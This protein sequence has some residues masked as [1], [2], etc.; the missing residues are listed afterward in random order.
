MARPPGPLTG[1]PRLALIADVSPE[2]SGGGFLLLHRLLGAYPPDRL[3][4]IQNPELGKNDPGARLAGVTYR[5]FRYRIPRIYRN[6]FNPA[7]PILQARSMRRHSGS[8]AGMIKA[9]APEA[10]LTIP[11][12]YLWSSAAAVAAEMEIPLHLI[13]HDDW[14]SNTTFRKPG[15]VWDGVRWGCRRVLGSIYRQAVSRLCVSPGMEEYC[16]RWFGAQGTLLYPSWGEDSPKQQ[17][18]VRD[19]SSGPPVLAFCGMIH[20]DGTTDLLRKLAENVG[21]LG[22]HLDMYT[23]LSQ[24]DLASRNLGD[25]VVRARGF[26]PAAAMGEQIGQTADVLFLPASFEPRERDD[27]ATL[28]PSKLADYTA[29]GLP[30]L[31][32][33]PEY[34]SAARW[35]RENPE[36]AVLVT[37]PA[38]EAAWRALERLCSE[39][40]YAVQ[41]AA[42]GLEAGKRYFDLKAARQTLY[43]ALEGD[44]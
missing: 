2:R 5:D 28:F 44:R 10:I 26:L 9:F 36:A 3:L 1:L 21:A 8:I 37:D 19:K 17:V 25:P 12:W 20:Q 23:Q 24:K 30:V 33:G 39:R 7:W 14:P 34:S 35:V 41:V 40:N 29:I 18:R 22:G 13:V 32:W 43:A 31:V 11:H 27:V 15:L 16:Q 38:P 4:V 42:A 6:R